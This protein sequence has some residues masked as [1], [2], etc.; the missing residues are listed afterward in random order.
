MSKY[1][2]LNIPILQENSSR[3]YGHHNIEGKCL[4][5]YIYAFP[6]EDLILTGPIGL[7]HD[8]DVIFIYVYFFYHLGCV[9]YYLLHVL[10]AIGLISSRSIKYILSLNT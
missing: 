4:M 9:S 8:H 2:A 10:Y 6:L 7:S 5:E 3:S 1:G